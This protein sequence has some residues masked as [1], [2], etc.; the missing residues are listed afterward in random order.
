VSQEESGRGGKAADGGERR[1][2]LIT[3]GEEKAV[4][5]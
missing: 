1:R 4:K 5:M 3:A 2:G